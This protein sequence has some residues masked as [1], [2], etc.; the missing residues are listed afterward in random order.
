MGRSR[1]RLDVTLAD[2]S[3]PILI[4]PGLL[5]EAGAVLSEQ[6]SSRAVMVVSD[7]RVMGLYGRALKDSLEQAGM[8][9]HQETFPAG[10]E[11]KNLANCERLWQACARD[12]LDRS[13]A[14]IA[15]GGGISG[16][17]AGFV[18]ACWMRGVTLVQIPTTLLA[19][20]D[21]SVGGKTG[22]NSPAGKNL[23]G[24]FKQPACVLIDPE[25][26][27]SMDAREYRSGLAEVLKYG[28]IRDVS[29]FQWQEHH[30][31]ELANRDPHAVSY[32]VAQCCRIKA[33]Y[34]AEDEFEQGVRAQLNYGHTFGHAL[35]LETR[36]QQYLHGEAVGLG[37]RMAAALAESLGMLEDPQ[38]RA[39]Q[40]G[41]L[42]RYQL[43]LTHVALDPMA[44]AARMASHCQLDKKVTHGRTRFILPRRLGAVVFQEAPD[45]A[46][47][48]A[49]FASALT[50]S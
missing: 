26:L 49:A 47:V 18:A 17:I 20:V 27:S 15:L 3:Y 8:R 13:G 5:G 44:A 7:E 16:D 1:T 36:Y 38:L 12:R 22:I 10:E 42:S 25:L 11:Q 43:P 45:T 46:Q 2:R 29:F 37:M 30:A 19:M 24:A 33:E 6:L 21:S 32:A 23:I 39:R 48:V 40:D 9:V 28:V 34:V 4:E 50:S 31:E 14:I 41:L 35:E